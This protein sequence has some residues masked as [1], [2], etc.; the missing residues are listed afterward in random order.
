[1]A[2]CKKYSLSE[3]CPP[4]P[5]FFYCIFLLQAFCANC[6]TN[7]KFTAI[8]QLP[9]AA[10]REHS[11]SIMASAQGM[12]E[13][14]LQRKRMWHLSL[15]CCFVCF[16][17]LPFGTFSWPRRFLFLVILCS[18]VKQKRNLFMVVIDS[19]EHFP[20]CS[21]YRCS[22]TWMIQSVV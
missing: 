6:H 15:F 11:V 7:G 20:C 8:F 3:P 17:F 1:M 12:I 21:V 22:M 4:P 10:G 16:G 9:L 2:P 5:L 14:L 13:E 18:N 19:P